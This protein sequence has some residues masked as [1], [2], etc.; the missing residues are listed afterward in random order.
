[1]GATTPALAMTAV[2]APSALVAVE[3]AEHMGLDGDVAFHRDRAAAALGDRLDD[4]VRRLAS[5]R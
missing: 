4:N 3:H 1:M 5:L 2:S